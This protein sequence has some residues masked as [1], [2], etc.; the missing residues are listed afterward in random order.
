MKQDIKSSLLIIF[1]IISQISYS[2]NNID[3]LKQLLNQITDKDKPTILNKL[4]VEYM[5]VSPETSVEYAYQAIVSAKKHNDYSNMASALKTI[6]SI[7]YRYGLIDSAIYYNNLSL[8]LYLT[9][10]DSAG[11]SKVLNNLGIFYNETGNYSKALSYHIQSLKIKQAINDSTGIAF[12]CNNIGAIYYQQNQHESALTYFGKALN[13]SQS[14]NDKNS[15]QSALS[16]IGLI[17]LNQ[18]HYD[19][20]IVAF[21]QSYKLN[22]L[23]N[24]I[25]NLSDNLVQLGNVYRAK[26]EFNSALDYYFRSLNLN[27]S[28]GITEPQLLLSIAISYDSLA[29]Y[30]NSIKYYKRT[31]TI[32]KTSNNTDILQQAYKNISK[33]YSISTNGEDAYANLLL[34]NKLNDSL[35]KN[36]T[37][38]LQEKTFIPPTSSPIDS[39]II[40]D[41]K[42]NIPT[43]INNSY[44]LSYKNIIIFSLLIFILLAMLILI[45]KCK[46]RK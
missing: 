35:S 16:N 34:L 43:Q 45:S 31:I 41:S 42:H 7:N 44:Y 15:E 4:S 38:Q 17:Y 25:Y 18:S 20:A 23:L 32:A 19:K 12:S 28:Y 39:S 1:I 29:E 9:L 22:T 24:N 3:S 46:K 2:G 21:K 26:N 10:K 27:E 14:I 6:G 33:A 30:T 36:K 13:I 37:G 11:I 8:N 40:E 5:N